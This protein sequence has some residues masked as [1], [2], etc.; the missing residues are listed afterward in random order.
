MST[1]AKRNAGLELGELTIVLRPA[2]MHL[3]EYIGTRRQLQAEGVIPSD[4]QWPEGF[5]YAHWESDGIAF[6]LIRKRPEGAKGPRKMFSDCDCWRLRM[7][8]MGRDYVAD[9]I[10]KKEE[11]LQKLRFQ[12]S[13]AGLRAFRKN[14]HDLLSAHNDCAFQAFKDLVPALSPLNSNRRKA[15]KPAARENMTPRATFRSGGHDG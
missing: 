1:V 3:C 10:R 2:G 8:A 6:S 9:E 7:E 14:L 15:T 4:L 13:A 5:S 11:E 12:H